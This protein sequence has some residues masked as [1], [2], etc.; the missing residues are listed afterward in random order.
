VSPV[1][2][3]RHKAVLPLLTAVASAA[4]GA[5]VTWQALQGRVQLLELRAER[6]ETE[7]RGGRDRLERIEST[8]GTLAVDMGWV[9]DALRELRG[10]P[11]P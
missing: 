4:L 3:V 11:T 8:L 10:R 1:E 2:A 5:G 9:K 7:T 6:A